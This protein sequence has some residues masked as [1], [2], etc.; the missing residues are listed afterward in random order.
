M[1]RLVHTKFIHPCPC[2]H[3][4]VLCKRLKIQIARP[5]LLWNS[6]EKSLA[7]CKT[8][9]SCQTNQFSQAVYQT[10][11][12]LKMNVENC[13]QPNCQVSKGTIAIFN[14]LQV[15]PSVPP[16]VFDMLFI[17]SFHV[18]SCYFYVLLSLVAVSALLSFDKFRDTASSV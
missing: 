6:V 5:Y 1:S 15:C 13:L 10:L 16:F 14:V 9:A 2:L 12:I 17:P 18:L 4:K 7:N 8:T 3:L 11:Q